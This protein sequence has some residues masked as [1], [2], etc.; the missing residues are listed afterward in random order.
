IIG[1]GHI[2]LRHAEIIKRNEECHLVALIDIN[3]SIHEKLAESFPEVP[4]YLSLEKYLESLTAA[5]VLVIATPNGF[6]KQHA[7]QAMDH[8][9]NVLVEK[10]LCL[11]K[12]DAEE[13]I[14]RSVDRNLKVFCVM[15]NRYSPPSEWLKS[16][17]ES[18]VPGK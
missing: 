13:I 18:G 14:S 5:D 1:C 4:L 6:H 17:M 3:E 8:G 2:G 10:P 11:S 12:A 7:L 15:Q 16:I 9:L